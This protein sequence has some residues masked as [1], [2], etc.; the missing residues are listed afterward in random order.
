VTAPAAGGLRLATVAD[1]AQLL[2]LWEVLFDDGADQQP[3]WRSHAEEWFGRFVDDP[4][5]ARFPLVEV[6]GDV[7]ATAI[8][9]LELGV[10]NPHCLRGRTVRLANVFTA[11]DHRGHGYA[12]ELVEDVIAWARSIGAD[13][14][15]LSSTPEGQRIYE[16]AGF[17]LTSAPRM[18]LVL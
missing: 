10:P 4:A 16:R 8:G 3:A 13:R 15:D 11:P 2:S 9:T 6:G 5:V 18:K 12:T 14:V 1:A 17:T 7:V